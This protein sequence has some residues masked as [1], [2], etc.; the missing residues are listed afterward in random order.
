MVFPSSQVV[1]LRE[2][3]FG[4]NSGEPPMKSGDG[5]MWAVRSGAAVENA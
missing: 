3:D 5:R 2:N 1:F 4:I